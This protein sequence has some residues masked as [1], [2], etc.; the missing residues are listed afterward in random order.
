MC[1]ED[2]KKKKS[3]F[4]ELSGTSTGCQG[5]GEANKALDVSGKN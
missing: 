5:K 4:E 2:L 1:L 3:L